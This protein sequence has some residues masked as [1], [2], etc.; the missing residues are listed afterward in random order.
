VRDGT[1]GHSAQSGGSAEEGAEGEPGERRGALERW[2]AAADGAATAVAHRPRLVLGLATLAAVAVLAR[3]SLLRFFNADEIEAIHSG[4]LVLQGGVPYVDFFQHH[5]PLLYYLLAPV[6]AVFGEG[7]ESVV[8]ARSVSF[9]FALGI[10]ALTWRLGQLEFDGVVA[11]AAT[12]LLATT[13]LFGGKVIEVR[14]DV[15]M[16]F[17]GLAAVLL[18]QRHA[19][20]RRRLHLVASAAS[21]GL[22]FLF[23]QKVVFLLSGLAVLGL[24]RV[25]RRE[26]RW[27]DF[28]VYAAVFLCTLAP[29]ALLLFS[30][31]ALEPYVFLNWRLN[32]PSQGTFGPENTILRSFQESAIVWVFA[33]VSWPALRNARQRE[34]A[35]LALSA[36]A[37]VFAVHR[38][39]PQYYMMA[40]PFLAILAAGGLRSALGDRP[41]LYLA[42]LALAC[43]PA[44]HGWVVYGFRT[45]DGQYARIAY[46]LAMTDEDDVVHDGVPS[47]NLFRRDLDWFWFS[48][49]PGQCLDRYRLRAEYDYDPIERIEELRPKLITSL[50]IDDMSDPR[51]ASKYVPSEEFNDIWIRVVP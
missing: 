7:L 9:A 29:F 36:L 31:G 18:F 12:L 14:P 4:W 50:L 1:R 5:H 20:T 11:S 39:W 44:A 3:V 16:T 26:A 19:R 23:L 51:I 42:I 10:F 30:A 15:P 37:L 33:I 34:V 8:A 35:G 43:V 32:L 6:V 21:A 27:S 17:F 48:L 47:F 24:V 41:R 46:G 28:G 13:V 22:A 25:L 40:M 49:K 38:P 45:N 2:L